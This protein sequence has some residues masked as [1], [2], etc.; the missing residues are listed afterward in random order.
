MHC[1]DSKPVMNSLWSLPID[2]LYLFSRTLVDLI[3]RPDYWGHPLSVCY[4]YYLNA[5][6]YFLS[7]MVFGTKDH[8]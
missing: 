6:S 4:R 1:L 7:G 5:L 8:I 2:L 3:P